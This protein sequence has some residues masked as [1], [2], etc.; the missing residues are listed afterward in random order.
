MVLQTLLKGRNDMKTAAIIAEYNPFH[1][2]HQY[3][4]HQTRRAAGADAVIC[5]M[6][7]HF[8]QR[9]DCA[10]A[11]KWTRA[12]AALLGGAD[13]VLELPVYY[14]LSVAQLFAFGAVST[15]D[16]LGCVDVLS[17]GIEADS[18]A[19]LSFL[20]EKLAFE[21]DKIDAQTQKYLDG[22]TGYPAAR[23]RALTALYGADASLFAAPNNMLALEYMRQLLL[24]NST[25][26][27]FGVPRRGAGH[28]DA[29]IASGF[30]SA[31]AL[32][33]ALQRGG[34]ISGAVPPEAYALYKEAHKKGRFPV[35]TNAFDQMILSFLRRSNAGGLAHILDMP[36]GF[37]GRLI[38]MAAKAGTVDELIELCCVKHY[39]RARIRRLLFASFL[40]IPHLGYDKAPTYVRVLGMNQTGQ[41][42]LS[43]MRESCRLPVITKAANYPE[44]DTDL[45]FRLDCRSTDLYSLA[46][47]APEARKAG[48][49][50]TTSP[51]IL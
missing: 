49:D 47:P 22:H 32:R 8:V 44:K 27:P 7:G 19:P 38:T 16:A 14:S 50:F 37:A 9:G 40:G 33:A 46:L 31:S 11:D 10:V 39:T 2:G 15:L 23:Q 30:A 29:H 6:S 21:F 12:H 20:A 35:F 28:H 5:I 24:Q 1:N 13:L 51:I 3:H 34:D 48:A 41:T 17:F 4:I 25:I 45:L 42:L 36:H 18:L 43:H 26:H